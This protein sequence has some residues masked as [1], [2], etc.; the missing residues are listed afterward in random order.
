MN[1]V[2]TAEGKFVEIQGTGEHAE[3]SR[4][5]LNDLLDLAEGGLHDLVD[6]QRRSLAAELGEAVTLGDWN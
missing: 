4:S 5:E 1:V 6:L 3:F 2:M